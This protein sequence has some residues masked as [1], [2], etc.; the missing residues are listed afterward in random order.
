MA[1]HAANLV[2]LASPE[3]DA[4]TTTTE[5]ATSSFEEAF[6]PLF[7]TAFKAAYRILRDTPAAEDV[8]AEVIGRLHARWSRLGQTGHRD[9]WVV[10]AATNQALD[11]VKRGRAPAMEVRPT[12]FEDEATSRLALASAMRRLSRR[13]RE[14]VALHYLVGLPEREVAVVLGIGEGS[15]RRHL[16]RALRRL[17]GELGNDSQGG[18]R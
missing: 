2:S 11:V 1:V 6:W 13:Q 14:A 7:L 17:R 8:A 18:E 12:G 10:R 9:A 16:G 3:L 5:A 4:P 15:V